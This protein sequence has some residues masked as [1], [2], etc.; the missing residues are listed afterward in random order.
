M[1]ADICHRLEQYWRAQGVAPDSDRAKEE[2]EG[3]EPRSHF[4]VHLTRRQFVLLVRYA[5]VA[6]SK[7]RRRH[8]KD[9]VMSCQIREH[10]RL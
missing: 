10:H 2:E 1:L 5:L 9:F 8:V 4:S 6:N 3:C 7:G